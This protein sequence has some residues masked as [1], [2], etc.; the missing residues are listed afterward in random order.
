MG[1]PVDA[2]LD[3]EDLPLLELVFLGIALDEDTLTSFGQLDENEL[4][5]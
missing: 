1:A 3:L 4:T 5:V 2:R